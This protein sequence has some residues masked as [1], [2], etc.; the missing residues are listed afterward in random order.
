[1]DPEKEEGQKQSAVRTQKIRFD[2]TRFSGGGFFG[3]LAADVTRKLQAEKYK[4]KI[5]KRCDICVVAY[6]TIAS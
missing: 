2:C 6:D 3:R 1:M 5:E 4:V